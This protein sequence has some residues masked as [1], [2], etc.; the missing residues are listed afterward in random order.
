M[1]GVWISTA[2]CGWWHFIIGNIHTSP[3]IFF[4]HLVAYFACAPP[5]PFRPCCPKMIKCHQST[6]P[7]RRAWP[8]VLPRSARPGRGGPPLWGG[9]LVALNHFWS[10]RSRE[11]EGWA[12]IPAHRGQRS[13]RV[14]NYFEINVFAITCC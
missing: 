14:I 11:G 9:G 10:A 8:G 7:W 13:C 6:T 12:W 4:S 5:P 3:P 2:A 1:S